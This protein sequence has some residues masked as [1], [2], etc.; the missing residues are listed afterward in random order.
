MLPA[1][2]ETSIN[3][4]NHPPSSS[5]LIRHLK[6]L[7]WICL[8]IREITLLLQNKSML[9]AL[10]QV[11]LS[12]VRCIKLRQLCCVVSCVVWVQLT[13]L[14][15]NA[16]ILYQCARVTIVSSDT[17]LSEKEKVGL[18]IG[19]TGVDFKLSDSEKYFEYRL[20][21]TDC[22]YERWRIRQI[23]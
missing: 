16:L 11:V 5:V 10:R 19:V 20:T 18:H 14:L 23:E 4:T 2:S 6:S 21:I 8:R 13:E 22:K 3:L 7:E 9:G 12:C 1:Q 15:L 17:G